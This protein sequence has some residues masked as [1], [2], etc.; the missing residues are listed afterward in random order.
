M[1]IDGL[2][3][4]I[5]PTHNNQA[6]LEECLDSLRGQSYCPIEIIV[7]LNGCSD[8]TAQ[9]LKQGYPEVKAL[10]NPV[11]LYYARALNQGIESAGGEFI[12]SL[13]DD[14]VLDRDFIREAR[15]AF[16]INEDIGMVSSKVFRKTGGLIDTTGLF[17]GRCRKPIERGYG[18]KDTGEFDSAGYAYG[19]CGAA[20][21]YRRKML[22]DIKD[23][24][25]YFDRRFK[26]FYE[27]LDLS[28]RANRRGWRCYYIPRAV[29]YH[30]RGKTARKVKSAP[31]FLNK[32][33]FVSLP[34][35]LQ[36][37]LIK[38]RYLTIIKNDSLLGF[39][40]NLPFILLYEIKMWGCVF[41]A[42]IF[43]MI[44]KRF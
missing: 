23:E 25:G 32:W 38:N 2:V 6:S 44:F 16:S 24:Y 13:N 7:I 31:V 26:M 43:S 3:T 35:P 11:N 21:F 14:C 36:L 1:V 39:I 5:I 30:Y 33:Y 10:A 18:R 27:D 4:V 12:L 17:L 42:V 37:S 40:I 34:L 8:A 9:K 22:D 20:G 41:A 15:G 28:W 19:V 29:A